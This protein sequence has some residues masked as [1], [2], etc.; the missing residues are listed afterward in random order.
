MKAAIRHY[1]DVDRY[2]TGSEGSWTLCG[3]PWSKQPTGLV[4]DCAE[5]ARLRRERPTSTVSEWR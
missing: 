1:K 3:E 2:Y 4:T 5:C